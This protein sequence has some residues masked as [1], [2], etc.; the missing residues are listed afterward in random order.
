MALNQG[1]EWARL[2]LAAVLLDSG[3]LE[4]AVNIL[5]PWSRA[6]AVLLKAAAFVKQGKAQ[7]AGDIYSTLSEEDM[8]PE[9]AMIAADRMALL[10]LFKP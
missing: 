10:R 9:N 2:A 3:R 4:E 7:E 6:Q 8:P 1:D 5:S